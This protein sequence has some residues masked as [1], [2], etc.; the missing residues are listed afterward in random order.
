M[1]III[2]ALLTLGACSTTSALVLTAE[3]ARELC[4]A[5]PATA[6]AIAERLDLLTSLDGPALVEAICGARD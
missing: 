4:Q 6:V 1:R 2:L 3:Q 5:D